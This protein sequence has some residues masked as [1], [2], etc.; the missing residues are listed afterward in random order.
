MP[1]RD[2]TRCDQRTHRTEY[3]LSASDWYGCFLSALSSRVTRSRS[4]TRYPYRGDLV[5]CVKAIELLFREL[6]TAY[7]LADV[8]SG[9]LHATHALLY[10]AILIQ[11]RCSFQR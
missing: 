10:A 6:K 4:I 3:T 1:P 2:A 5:V 7:R 11:H 9:N 8:P